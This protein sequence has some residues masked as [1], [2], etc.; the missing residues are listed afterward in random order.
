MTATDIN[1][2]EQVSGILS[3]VNGGTGVASPSS[4]NLLVGNGSSAMTTVAPGNSGNMLTSTGTGWAS[5]APV[6]RIGSTASSATPSINIGLYDQYNITALATTV[7][8]VSYTGSPADGQRLIVRIK[9]NGTSQSIT[10]GSSN[11][12]SSGVATLLT[13]TVAGKTHTLGFIY[14][15]ALGKWVCLAVDATGY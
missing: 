2:A 5:S 14:D 4:G 1:I 10:W 7:T 13:A 15:G 6:P 3:V 8:S 12:V 9:D 11:W